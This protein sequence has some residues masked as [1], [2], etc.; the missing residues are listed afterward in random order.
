MPIHGPM[1]EIHKPFT[2]NKFVNL[3]TKY[4]RAQQVKRRWPYVI[5]IEGGIAAG[6]SDFLTKCEDSY[7]NVMFVPEPQHLWT[8]VRN[9]DLNGSHE[10][11]YGEEYIEED[12]RYN[13]LYKRWANPERY[14][15]TFNI[16]SL[17]TRLE[18]VTEAVR[19]ATL[20]DEID[21]VFVERSWEAN[22]LFAEVLYESKHFNEL[23]RAMYEGWMRFLSHRAQVSD[24]FIFLENQAETV[25]ERLRKRDRVEE[26]NISEYFIDRIAMKHEVWKEQLQDQNREFMEISGDF[27]LLQDPYS[28][29]NC[30]AQLETF[31]FSLTG[32]PL[33]RNADTDPVETLCAVSKIMF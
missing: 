9:A 19:A 33:I 17:I 7:L 15:F 1:I 30:S 26:E 10:N 16:W 31:V 8:N 32:R 4:M 6:K 20:D 3:P 28:W 27:D 14:S 18:G 5:S 22:R 24:G 11:P 21:F 25:L 2:G 12:D 29:E 13:L 23:E